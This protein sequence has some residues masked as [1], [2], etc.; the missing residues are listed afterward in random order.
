MAAADR[1]MRLLLRYPLAIALCALLAATSLDAASSGVRG[2]WREPHGAVIRIA[3]CGPSLCLFIAALSPG[4]HP[5]TDVRNPKR[6]LRDRSLCG[7]KIGEGFIERDP[8]HA[9]GG[10]IYD[11]RSGRTYRSSMTAEG[12]LLKLRG[13]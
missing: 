1:D 11:P 2:Y 3:P 6:E 10:R 9:D 12:D 5:A 7:L 8:E 4:P 13:Y